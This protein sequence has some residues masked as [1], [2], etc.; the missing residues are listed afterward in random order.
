MGLR[1]LQYSTIVD[2]GSYNTNRRATEM[3]AVVAEMT[4]LQEVDKQYICSPGYLRRRVEML[5]CQLVHRVGADAKVV[6]L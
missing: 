1:R 5:L 6:N 4:A 2:D 3:A